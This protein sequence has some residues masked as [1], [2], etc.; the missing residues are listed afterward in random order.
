LWEW[1][2]LA[3]LDAIDL[4]DQLGCCVRT[5]RSSGGDFIG[6]GGRFAVWGSPA[7]VR[8]RGRTYDQDLARHLW[9]VSESM[10]GM[11]YTFVAAGSSDAAPK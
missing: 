2:A 11:R 1:T 3:L 10:T 9:Q 8:S 6:P 7:R 5:R 4:G